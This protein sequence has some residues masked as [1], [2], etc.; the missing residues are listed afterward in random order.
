MNNMRALTIPLALCL[1]T[2]TV[3]AQQPCRMEFSI[4]G[5]AGKKIFL[6]NYYGNQLFYTDSAVADA[7][8]LAVFARKSGYKPGLYV[9]L[10]GQ[11]RLEVVVNEP[12]VKMATETTDLVGKLRVIESRENTLHH[13]DRKAATA[14]PEPERTERLTALADANKGT[15]VASLIRMELEPAKVEVKGPDGALDSAAT[16]D[17]YRAHY[18]DNT[19][20][21]DNRIV[22]A[23]VFQ[24]RLEMLLAVGL[25]QKP[26]PIVNYLDSL[27]ARAGPAEDVK[28]FIVSLATKKYAEQPTQGLGAVCVRMAQRYVCTEPGGRASPDWK[29][30]DGW[31]KTCA[32]AARKATLLI[33]AKTRDIV[34][35]DTTGKKWIS[36]HDMPQSCVVVALWGPHCSHCKQAI[37]LLYEKYASEWKAMDV[38]VYAVAE[39][40]DG[41]LFA[42]WKKFVKENKLD[43]TNVGVPWPEYADWRTNPER[44]KGSPTNRESVNY[45]ETWEMTGTPR[46]YV[47]DKERRMVSQPASL[48][49]LF[50]VVK[51]HQAKGK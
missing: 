20:L 16:T 13:V 24:N 46:F 49:D 23:P 1:S 37:P 47:L 30:E 12:L 51:E 11:G 6:A 17:R 34:L 18:W 35:A 15:L 2:F 4:A 43:W 45:A 25:Q 8:D 28:R 38:G 32:K 42:D 27:I 39:T 50:N 33:G 31:R 22:G 10:P 9:V 26:D 36:L 41:E 3:L 14:L 29:P 21:T 5:A 40:T 7:Q 19:D 44:L 48:N